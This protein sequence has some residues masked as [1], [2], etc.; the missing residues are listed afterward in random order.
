[1]KPAFLV[2]SHTHPQQLYRLVS[3]LVDMYNAPVAI[4]HDFDKSSID[5]SRFA[6]LPVRFVRPHVVTNWGGLP[7]VD[8]VLRGLELLQGWQDPDWFTLLSGSDYPIRRA[9]AVLD[10]LSASSF[11]GYLDHRQIRYELISSWSPGTSGPPYGFQ[12]STYPAKAYDR[13]ISLQWSG[14]PWVDRRLRF[15]RRR[16]TVRYPAI[17]RLRSPFRS[18]IECYA[19]EFWLTGNRRVLAALLARGALYARLRAHYASR[20]NVD[21][22]LIHTILCNSPL[23]ISMDHRRYIDWHQPSKH[24]KTLDM[25]DFESMIRSRRWFARKFL[26][27]DQVLDALDRHLGLPPWSLTL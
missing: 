15:T 16:I 17:A 20:P 5:V 12:R 25:S 13:Y 1:M 14:V 7:V 26:P 10:E 11:D 21:E 6:R 4:H 23:R 3:R 24:P 9:E 27:D 19:G 22:S 2:L 8:A 18:G